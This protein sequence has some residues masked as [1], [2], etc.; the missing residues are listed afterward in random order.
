[1]LAPLI[2][3]E[4]APQQV[5]DV[6]KQVKKRRKSVAAAPTHTT[7]SLVPLVP[8]GFESDEEGAAPVEPDEPAVVSTPKPSSTPQ[9]AQRTPNTQRIHALANKLERTEMQRDKLKFQLEEL[10]EDFDELVEQNRVL[11]ERAEHAETEARE[12]KAQIHALEESMRSG[13]APPPQAAVAAEPKSSATPAPSSSSLGISRRVFSASVATP[14]LATPRPAAAAPLEC[15][16]TVPAVTVPKAPPTPN[17]LGLSRVM[18]QEG[19]QSEPREQ[20]PCIPVEVTA[21]ASPQASEAEQAAPSCATPEPQQPPQP[22]SPAPQQPPTGQQGGAAAWLRGATAKAREGASKA[23]SKA[24]EEASKA[25][26][27]LAMRARGGEASSAPAAQADGEGDGEDEAIEEAQQ[28]QEEATATEESPLPETP[29]PLPPPPSVSKVQ[30]QPTPQAELAPSPQ[31]QP[32]PSPA[33]PPPPPPPPAAAAADDQQH[34]ETSAAAEEAEAQPVPEAEPEPEPEKKKKGKGGRRRSSMGLA[35]EL[36]SLDVDATE[37]P[38]A[39]KAAAVAPPPGRTTRRRS[40]ATAPAPAPAEEAPPT[41]PPP[42]PPPPAPEAEEEQAAAAVPPPPPP[43]PQAA[44]V[45]A[46]AGAEPAEDKEAEAPPTPPTTAEELLQRAGDFLERA[47]QLDASPGA[48]RRTNESD[49]PP[50]PPPPPEE[51]DLEAVEEQ[52]AEQLTA[53]AAPVDAMAEDGAAAAAAAAAD[54]EEC[55]VPVAL[56]PTA[57]AMRGLGDEASLLEAAIELA[58]E[59]WPEIAEGGAA[60]AVGGIL[61]EVAA[62]AAMQQRE[63]ASKPSKP[64]KSAKK[65]DGSGKS[66]KSGGGRR[67]RFAAFDLSAVSPP[68]AQRQGAEKLQE[69]LIERLVELAKTQRDVFFPSAGDTPAAVAA[70]RYARCVGGALAAMAEAG[71][72]LPEAL[73]AAARFYA[74]E[75]SEGVGVRREPVLAERFQELLS[76]SL[77]YH[78]SMVFAEEEGA[79]PSSLLQTIQ[80]RVREHAAAHGFE[81]NCAE[82]AEESFSAVVSTMMHQMHSRSPLLAPGSATREALQA[83]QGGGKQLIELDAD[84]KDGLLQWS[85]AHTVL[86]QVFGPREQLERL[87]AARGNGYHFEK[88]ATYATAVRELEL[89]DE[90][91]LAPLA[92]LQQFQ[93]QLHADVGLSKAAREG[94]MVYGMNAKRRSARTSLGGGNAK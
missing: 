65:A 3:D 41:P 2:Q 58:T 22:P 72:G 13:N 18:Q 93:R 27:A 59:A 57:E 69:Q 12:C 64:S 20:P 14:V 42:P 31:P 21:P 45:E 28:V 10:E 25:A 78:L 5:Q 26:A 92:D 68:K 76:S 60:E 87:R 56:L 81:I 75:L 17:A 29:S 37:V 94:L 73:R 8:Y 53:A 38:K 50:P 90:A 34:E 43:P 16:P 48:Y 51:E 70:R 24:R 9:Y 30:S 86:L 4:N 67:V 46:E 80:A 83:A 88:L 52:E 19:V 66:G 71:V 62:L 77:R 79:E 33:P 49:E 63:R 23:A 82:G 44:E 55:V 36:A 1:M 11:R 84:A 54:E 32:A 89:E 7:T 6:K 85:Q 61:R 40:M 47:E 15:P 35:R 91:Y 74:A 39:A